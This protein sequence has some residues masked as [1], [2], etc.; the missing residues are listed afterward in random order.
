MACALSVE[1]AGDLVARLDFLERRRPSR[2]A[3]GLTNG[4]RGANRQPGAMSP[5]RRRHRARDRL[6]PLPLGGGE[7]DARDR[8]QEPLGVGVQR[9]LEELR[10][11]APP[12][13]PWRA[14]I[15]TTRCAVSAMTPM[16]WV[17]SMI[18][19]LELGLQLVE[20]LQDLGLDGHVERGGRLVGDQ[21]LRIARQRHG[22]HDAL[23]HAARELVRVLLD[24]AL[25][26][27]DVDEL[28]HLDRLVHGVAA[29]RAPRAGGWPRR[30]ARRTVNTGLSEVI[31]SWKI[32][33]ISLPRIFR[34]WAGGQ[35]DA[36]C[37]RCRG[38]G[39]RRCVPGGCGISRMIAERGHASCR[40]RTRRP[41]RAS[42]P[43]RCGGR[44]RRRR[45]RR[46][47]R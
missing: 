8:A 38:S 4:Q 20:Q 11:P 10:R 24:P 14:Y 44:C 5:R 43:C 25:G 36:G 28:E 23:P 22:D 13:R 32:I 12:R 29:A 34:I 16:S 21:E 7:V 33:E 26:V 47:R 19:M 31:G 45:G 1:P 41:R 35:V 37:G 42:R 46:P 39:P 15:T 9:L 18:A 30:S 2:S 40:S 27:G 17:M 3:S 6:E